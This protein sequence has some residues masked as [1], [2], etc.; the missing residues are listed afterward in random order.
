ME[1]M[2]MIVLIVVFIIVKKNEYLLILTKENNNNNF[3]IIKNYLVINVNQYVKQD[4]L[5]NN[6]I[7]NVKIY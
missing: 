7:N 1:E 5:Q 4:V 6:V 2:F 3:Q